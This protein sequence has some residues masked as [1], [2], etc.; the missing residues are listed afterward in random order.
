LVHELWQSHPG[1]VGLV[2]GATRPEAMAGIRAAAP[3]V[4]WLVPGIGTQGGDLAQV[5]RYAGER[6]IINVSRGILYADRGVHFADG[7]RE[8]AR[9]FR[10]AYQQHRA[11]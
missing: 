10:N 11:H 6:A 7:A 3:E 9:E 4:P 8:A 5:A 2:V 1:Q